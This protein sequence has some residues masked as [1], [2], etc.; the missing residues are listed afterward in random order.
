MRL[1]PILALALLAGTAHAGAPTVDAVKAQLP[2][3]TKAIAVPFTYTGL[4]YLGDDADKITTCEGAFHAHGLIKDAKKLPQFVDCLALTGAGVVMQG[5]PEVKAFDPKH[6]PPEM[7]GTMLALQEDKTIE[8]DYPGKLAKL[9][10]D[11]ALV[12]VHT[13]NPNTGGTW[14]EEWT[15][16]VARDDKGA[17][18]LDGV[19]VVQSIPSPD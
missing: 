14:D 8:K 3:W 6:A 11:K 12:L 17:I 16:F 10:K 1:T 18:K 2:T 9:G 4:V 15:V 13:T 19:M 7:L 5:T